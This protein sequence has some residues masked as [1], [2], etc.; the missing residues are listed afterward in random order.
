MVADRHTR[1]QGLGRWCE[2]AQ[3][4]ERVA[5]PGGLR[6]DFLPSGGELDLTLE[7]WVDFYQV[8]EKPQER[9]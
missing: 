5:L 7:G 6:K 3:K 4:E 1:V 2:K 9:V 8:V